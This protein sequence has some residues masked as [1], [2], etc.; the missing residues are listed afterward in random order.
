MFS[1]N[2]LVSYLGPNVFQML[3]RSIPTFCSRLLSVCPVLLL[4]VIFFPSNAQKKKLLQGTL[5]GLKGVKSYDIKF[6][7][8]SM[9][10]GIDTPENQ[11]LRTK[12]KEW[13]ERDPGKGSAFLNEW[14]DGRQLQYEPT[15]I[16]NFETYSQVTLNDKSATYTMILKTTRTE[17]GWYAGVLAHP[18]EI[19]GELW[20]VESADPSKVIAKIGFYG[21]VGKTSRDDI[22]MSD[23]I[24]T[25]YEMA[26][27]GLGDFFK[28]KAR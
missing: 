11:Y 10:V 12:K 2:P 26:G 23:R 14:F 25:A 28:R 15:F 22:D 27:K 8:D 21:F 5:D 4:C 18:G 3:N 7:Y 19:D 1:Q 20:I 24:E 17:A 16:K 9:V 13:D 6:T